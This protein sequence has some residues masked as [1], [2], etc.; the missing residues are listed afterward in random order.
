MRSL[1]KAIVMVLYLLISASYGLAQDTTRPFISNTMPY[2][3]M[4]AV[5]LN[6]PIKVTFN[7]KM[8]TLLHY[9]ILPDPGGLNLT[10]TTDSLTAIIIHSN[11]VASQLYQVII[12][13][14][15]DIAGNKSIPDS[16]Q[17][18]TLGTTKTIMAEDFT[19]TWCQ[20]CPAAANGLD[21]LYNEV[22]DSLIVLAFHYGDTYQTTETLNRN[23]YYSVD[24][25]GWPSVIFGGTEWMVGSDGVG[26][27]FNNYNYYRPIFDS[28]KTFSYSPFEMSIGLVNYDLDARTGTIDIKIKNMAQ[29]TETGKLHFVVVER[30]IPYPQGWFGLYTVDFVVRDMIPDENGEAVSIAAGESLVVTRNYALAQNWA[31]GSCQ[32][33]AFVQRDSQDITQ[34]AE[35]RCQQSLVQKRYTTA[36]FGNG[37]GFYEPAETLKCA[38]YVQE[39]FADGTGAK[40]TAWTP[41]TFVTIPNGQWDLGS[42]AKDDSANNAADPFQVIVKPSATMN[43][44]H[45]VT[46]FLTKQVYNT[47]YNDTISVVDS[48]NFLVGTPVTIYTEGFEAGRSNWA[49]SGVGGGVDWDTTSAD[50]HSG[51]VCITDSKA[52]NYANVQSRYIWMLNGV[53]LSAL[54]SAMV[55]WYEKYNVLVNDYCRPE[56]SVN[57][58]TTFSP[59]TTA[60]NGIVSSWQ[61]RLADISA[62]CNTDNFR[63]RFRLTSNSADVADGWYVDDIEITGYLKTGVEGEKADVPRP[64]SI[65]LF[66]SYPNPAGRTATISYQVSSAQPVKLCIYDIAGRLVRSLVNQEQDPG[67]YS[68][69][70]DGTNEKGRQA[71]AGVYFYH[72]QTSGQNLTKKMVLVR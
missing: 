17:F 33:V 4:N 63:L 37:N 32:F 41:D 18:S 8:D 45:Q 59:V 56:L 61:K 58:S 22:G 35:L 51:T 64:A 44:G 53:D 27:T 24:T 70:W 12:D 40:V 52:G 72:L 14:A 30:S 7:E 48:F 49:D 34:G 66:N 16:I 21:Q 68:V 43:E 55:T 28:L 29:W 3:T 5:T 23:Y 42:I 46:V 67:R 11:F 2:D 9:K 71:S 62:Y 6:L 13:S 36:E 15:Y 69:T 31:L 1:S 39:Y 50:A 54:S 38:A 10:W 26:S 60:Y 57:G 20:Y 25:V 47:L 65:Q 19:G